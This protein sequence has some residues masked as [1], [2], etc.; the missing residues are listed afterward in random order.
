LTD[1]LLTL[2]KKIIHLMNY[3][4]IILLFFIVITS[5][6]FSQKGLRVS[7]AG[8]IPGYE[9]KAKSLLEG[10][11]TILNQILTETRYL[12]FS[13][14]NI[15]ADCYVTSGIL[16]CDSIRN[17]I[18]GRA[19]KYIGV[20]YKYG[21]SSETGFDC[22]GYVKFIYKDFGLLLPHSS[23]AQYK[24]SKHLDPAE[25]LPGDLV[26]FNTRGSNISHVGI[27]LGNNQFI[28]SPSRGGSVCIDSLGAYY[29][30]KHL[31]GFGSVLVG[32][33]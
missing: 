30:K 10:E 32:N 9:G 12:L 29:F 14:I 1:N 27:Y 28:H 33:N 24:M 23:Y 15:L 4:Y 22:S 19:F 20:R 17:N 25:A 6:A 21:Q 8:I 26:F 7:T 3:R 2:P 5:Q 18:I 31:R 11:E 13:N 16:R